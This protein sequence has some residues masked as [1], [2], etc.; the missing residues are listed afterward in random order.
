MSELKE[1]NMNR[2]IRV[3]QIV[4]RMMG[5]GVEATVMNHYRHID[6][7]RVQFDFYAQS[8]STVIPREEI[9]FLG[10]RMF[11]TPSYKNP[12]AYMKALEK[13]FRKTKPDIVHSNMNALSV[14]ALRAA[15][16]AGIKVRI[17]H[18]H[19]TSNPNERAKTLI[20][21]MLR[22]FAK[23]YPTHLAACSQ[24][25]AAWLFGE[26]TVRAGEVRIIRNALDLRN[27]VF[28]SVTREKYRSEL[29]LKGHELLVGQVGR[30]CFQKNQRLSL[31][32]FARVL[33]DY[34]DAVFIL[35]GEGDNLSML[36]QYA[37]RLGITENVRFIGVRD[38]VWAWYSAFDALLFPSTYEGLG[39]V[40]IEAQSEGLPV[41]AS[42][43]VPDEVDIVP[44]LVRHLPLDAG[45][46]TWACA[47]VQTAGVHVTDTRENHVD[48]LTAAGYDIRESAGQLADWYQEIV[49]HS[50][51]QAR[52]GGKR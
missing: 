29:G 42:D 38:D 51:N 40:A 30:L 20:K 45:V 26:E 34:P 4:G 8:D 52:S 50:G 39:M 47:L 43:Q 36:R 33:K 24:F 19:S 1:T 12:I 27:F 13:F 3:A 18:S 31:E 41:L 6:R 37:E 46:D 48:E 11:I 32:V 21:N 10:G 9:E 14:F 25:A 5:G 49:S 7:T 17:A 16:R 15:K 2:P 35:V 23:V 22:P 28:D 44:G